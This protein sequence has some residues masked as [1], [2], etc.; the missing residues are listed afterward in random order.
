M[1]MHAEVDGDSATLYFECL[2][3][4]VDSSG[5]RKAFDVGS[6]PITRS[7]SMPQLAGRCLGHLPKRPFAG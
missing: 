6:I 1:R 2:W 3:M 5:E 7:I 4:D